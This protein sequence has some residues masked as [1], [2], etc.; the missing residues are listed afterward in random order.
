M[1]GWRG[2]DGASSL[3]ESTPY[4]IVYNVDYQSH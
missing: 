3:C 2:T 1:C 4:N